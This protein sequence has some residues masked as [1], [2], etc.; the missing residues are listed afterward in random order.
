MEQGVYADV[1]FLINFSM[2]FLSLYICASVLHKKMRTLHFVLSASLGGVWSVA[3]LFADLGVGLDIT[4]AYIMCLWAFCMGQK[5]SFFDSIVSCFVFFASEMLLGGVMTAAVNIIG[6]TSLVNDIA[7]FDEGVPLWI[8]VILAPVSS[9]FTYV[10]GRIFGRGAGEKTVDVKIEN[11]GNSLSFTALVDSGNLLFDPMSGKAVIV[12]GYERVRRFLPEDVR[13]LVES[14]D[15][16][17]SSLSFSWA[18]RVR[19]IPASSLGS[20]K[21]LVG[22][23]PDKIS[24]KKSKIEISAVIA[25]DRHS[26]DFGG[27]DAII[28][29]SLMKGVK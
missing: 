7:L 26:T 16:D 18:R 14:C 21:I 13:S 27:C 4:V 22:F 25:L 6:H 10:S 1:L 29:T 15:T 9:L 19:L 2:D 23:V 20:R 8:F 17:I 24:L 12:V 11:E 5:F 28:P 3:A